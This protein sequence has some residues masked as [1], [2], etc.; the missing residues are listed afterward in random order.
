MYLTGRIKNI[1]ISGGINI[2]PEEVEEILM[3]HPN[4]KEVCVIPEEHALLGEVPIA[5][6]VVKDSTSTNNYIDT[7]VRVKN[8]NNKSFRKVKALANKSESVAVW[9]DEKDIEKIEVYERI[10]NMNDV[11]Q[12]LRFVKFAIKHPNKRRSQIMIVTTCTG[13]SLKTIY[14]MIKARWIIENSIFNNLKNHADLNHCFVHGGKAVEAIIYL[15]FIASNLFQLFKVRRIK[16]HVP[17][18]IELV[19]LLFKGMYLLKY[20]SKLIFDTG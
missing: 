12:P 1:I 5:K 8:N 9:D 13:M 10:F 17:I 6:L 20:E 18:Q 14:K 3:S 4:I 11:G 16:N 19:R 7:I 2:Y 15:M